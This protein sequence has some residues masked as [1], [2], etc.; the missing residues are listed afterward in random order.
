MVGIFPNDPAILRL[1]GSKL[2]EQQ[3]EWQLEDRRFFSMATM[4]KIPEP[5][6]LDLTDADLSSQPD[7]PIS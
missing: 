6:A 5:E 3:L 7:E 1:V 2:L 4:A